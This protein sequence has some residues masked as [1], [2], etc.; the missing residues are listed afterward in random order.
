M[1][2]P[3][4]R[5]DRYTY[6]QIDRQGDMFA[7]LLC[8]NKGYFMIIIHDNNNNNFTSYVSVVI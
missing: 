8:D 7:L 6:R 3:D 4:R 2:K 5:A 1:Y